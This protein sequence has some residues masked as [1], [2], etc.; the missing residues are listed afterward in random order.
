[1]A[2]KD[3]SL[4]EVNSLDEVP[5]DFKKFYFEKDGKVQKAD[6]SA[7]ASSLAQVRREN[8]QLN[9][10]LLAASE[11]VSAFTE[12]LGD[13]ADPEFIRT[14]QEKAARADN[15]PNESEI[16][17]RLD[18]LKQDYEKKLQVASGETERFQQIIKKN[19]VTDKLREALREVNAT[20]DGLSLLPE[21]MMDRVEVSYAENGEIE[22]KV[23]DKDGAGMYVTGQPASLVDLATELKSSHASLFKG[24]GASGMGSGQ[25]SV[26]LPSNA[27]S[28]WKMSD[29]ERIA[30][31]REH[32]QAAASALIE[33][34]E[35]EA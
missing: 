12:L 14:L 5:A 2:D 21:R 7:L 16:Q 10:K 19:T 9:T 34:S 13:N 20:E 4:P 22:L 24:S 30:F 35:I 3:F 23:L 18:T 8:D 33:K 25:N 6:P 31:T 32:G 26:N 1:M 15:A 28:W 29:D 17:R 27:K 11:R